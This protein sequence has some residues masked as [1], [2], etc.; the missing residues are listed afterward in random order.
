[1]NWLK[2]LPLTIA[3]CET[4]VVAVFFGRF[5]GRKYN[6][7][8]IY[9]ICYAVYFALNTL[10]SIYLPNIVPVLTI[11]AYFAIALILY[12]GTI[13]QRIFCGGLLT[14][15][16]FVTE[17]LVMV[18]LSFIFG[19]TLTEIAN[20]PV[21]YFGGAYASKALLFILAIVV[22][23]KRKTRVK[24]VPFTYHLFLLFVVYICVGL[25]I[26][27][28]MLINQTGE[29]ATILFALSE[30]AF[31]L[32]S[33]LVFFIFEKF[34]AFAEREMHTTL[35]EQQLFQ[36]EKMYNMM[37]QQNFEIRSIRHDM[38]N[39]LASIS[40][41]ADAHHYEELQSYISTYFA[42]SRSVI[43][44][45]ATGKAIVDALIAGKV[46]RAKSEEISLLVQTDALGEV[47]VNPVHLSIV[48]NNALDNA[49]EACC[50]LSAADGMRR[51]IK[52]GLKTE[53][54]YLVMRI[55]NSSLPVE[56]IDDE[57]LPTGKGDKL[58]HGFGLASIR[59][60]V[61]KYRGIMFYEY[62]G[63]EFVLMAQLFNGKVENLS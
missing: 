21:L 1:M 40:Q 51:Y 7:K 59:R 23:A 30:V 57:P 19:F 39:H 26:A 43:E 34:Q 46:A 29:A 25:S 9:I 4:V 11:S 24:P 20:R 31:M 52:L 55:T 27:D 28:I 50:A 15:Y 41:L 18:L 12:R 62:K 17:S 63:G 44:N 2:L 32:L 36:S 13:T 42:E 37:E 47:L 48:L 14:A 8:R 33:V 45:P 5:L 38:A 6:S 35:I 10:V 56:I 61:E 49:I 54:D 22:S 3:L 16:S 58:L 53:H 60:V